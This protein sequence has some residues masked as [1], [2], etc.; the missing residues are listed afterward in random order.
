MNRTLSRISAI[1]LLTALGGCVSLGGA[2]VPENLL[3]LTPTNALP[4]GATASG[5]MANAIAIIEPNAPQRL[6]VTRVPVQVTDAKIAYLEDAVWVE[7]PAKLF[8]RLLSETIAARGNRLV[9]DG[10]DPDLPA[11]TRLYGTMLDMGYDVQTSSVVVRYEAIRE[12][13]TGEIQTRRFESIVPG[14]PATAAGV[15]PALNQAANDV[16]GQIADWVG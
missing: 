12:F 6:D 2:D 10:A 7:K 8:R 5:T 1:A 9:I 11:Q 14:I 3:T 4:A 16:A 15:G 13:T